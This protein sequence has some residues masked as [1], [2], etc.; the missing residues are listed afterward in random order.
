MVG[1]DRR[2]RVGRVGRNVFHV[3]GE[4]GGD[5]ADDNGRDGV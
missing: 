4:Y 5:S 2:N 1:L 3:L